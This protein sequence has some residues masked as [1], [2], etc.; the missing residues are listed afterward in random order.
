MPVF[1]PVPLPGFLLL[2]PSIFCLFNKTKA[3]RPPGC[4]C[5]ALPLGSCYALWEELAAQ[6]RVEGGVGALP[7]CPDSPPRAPR[8]RRS[9]NAQVRGAP[10]RCGSLIF[11][12]SGAYLHFFL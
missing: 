10:L 5:L 11:L 9:Q 4:P 3:G 6:G 2:S 12:P 8:G 1:C 7:V